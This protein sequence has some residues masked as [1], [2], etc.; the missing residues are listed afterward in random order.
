MTSIEIDWRTLISAVALI[1]SVATFVVSFLTGQRAEIRGR[2]PVLVF[3][4]DPAEG[5]WVLRNV[6]NGPALNIVVAQRMDGS[7]FNPVKVPPLG[8]ETSFK[9]AWLGRTN[10]TGLGTTY[11]D[12]EG[13]AYTSTLGDEISRTFEGHRLPE[14]ADDEV[15]RYWSVSDR[16]S[17]SRWAERRS[18][19]RA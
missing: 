3:V 11:V 16:G 9:L 8:H 7:W 1:I 2:K 5:S 17:G 6:G 4:D 10:D 12:F 15:E 18:D 14:W 13:H 19:F